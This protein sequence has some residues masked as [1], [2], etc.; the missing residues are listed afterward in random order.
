MPLLNKRERE[1]EKKRKERKDTILS[2][3]NDIF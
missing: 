3:F 2:S 1:K